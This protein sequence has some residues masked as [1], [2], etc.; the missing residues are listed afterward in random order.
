MRPAIGYATICPAA[1]Q[2]TS[3]PITPG[4]TPV[5]S[6]IAGTIG[7]ITLYPAASSAPSAS[8]TP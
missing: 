6:E 2:V 1:K 8:R 4:P 3:R 5:R 7:A